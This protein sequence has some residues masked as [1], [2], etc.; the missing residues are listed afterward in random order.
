[1]SVLNACHARWSNITNRIKTSKLFLWHSGISFLEATSIMATKQTPTHIPHIDQ[2]LFWNV[3]FKE[4]LGILL[5]RDHMIYVAP[6]YRNVWI[7]PWRHN[8]PAGVSNHQPHDCL[9]NYLFRHRSKKIS[10]LRVTGLCARNSPVTAPSSDKPEELFPYNH[11][12]RLVRNIWVVRTHK[13]TRY[14]DMYGCLCYKIINRGKSH[15]YV[16]NKDLSVSAQ[17]Q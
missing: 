5:S 6:L 4:L 11:K 3:W 9:L 7:L 14:V 12:L 13:Y 2:T 17:T 15:E 8:G 10:K 1:M 16:N